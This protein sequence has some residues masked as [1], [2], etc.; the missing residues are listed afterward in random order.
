MNNLINPIEYTGPCECPICGKHMILVTESIDA[1]I[2]DPDNYK[3]I[4]TENIGFNNYLQCLNCCYLTYR[5]CINIEDGTV[6]Q[7]EDPYY[8]YDDNKVDDIYNPF[9]KNKL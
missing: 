2:I 3:P 4:I 8:T 7:W 5:I 6:S 1:T 9:I